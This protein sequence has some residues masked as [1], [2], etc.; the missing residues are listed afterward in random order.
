MPPTKK[1][2]NLF[3]LVKGL[4]MADAILR[5]FAIGVKVVDHVTIKKS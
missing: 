3:D 1:S 2:N 5:S 4:S